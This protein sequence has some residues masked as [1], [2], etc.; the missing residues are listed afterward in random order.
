MFARSGDWTSLLTLRKTRSALY[1]PLCRFLKQSCSV[2]DIELAD[3]NVIKE[4]G[5]F[6]DGKVQGYSISPPKKN[7]LT[8]QTSWCTR[9]LHKIV[10][11]RCRLDHIQLSN[12]FPRAVKGVCFAKGAENCNVLGNLLDKEV[13]NL[14]DHGFLKVQDLVDKEIWICTS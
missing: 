13:E 8:K 4:L 7:K 12:I 5:V 9:N 14:E 10:W 2:L 3:K 11:N 1:F 6:I